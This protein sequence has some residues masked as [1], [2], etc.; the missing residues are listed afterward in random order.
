MRSAKGPAKSR[1]AAFP[2]PSV[3][4]RD[5]AGSNFC[6]EDGQEGVAL[7]DFYAAAAL[8]A[9]LAARTQSGSDINQESI[10]DECFELADAMVAAREASDPFVALEELAAAA[11][12]AQCECNAYELDHGHKTG[13]WMPELMDAIAEALAI[14]HA[15]GT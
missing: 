12:R 2:R 15:E 10:A 4:L 13:C 3:W 14:A 6:Q 5:S 1:R 9:V 11:A 8:P 7:R